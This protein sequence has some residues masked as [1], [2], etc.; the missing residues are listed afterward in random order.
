MKWEKPQAIPLSPK[1][2]EAYC[3]GGSGAVECGNGVGGGPYYPISCG[4]GS[5]A[6]TVPG[7]GSGAAPGGYVCGSG[8]SASC[9]TGTRVSVAGCKTGNL[10]T[11]T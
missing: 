6:G 4:D 7:C 2:A 1:F 8:S 3:T 10:G 11:S 5:S 9:N